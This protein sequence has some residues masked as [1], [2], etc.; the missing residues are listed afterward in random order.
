[1]VAESEAHRLSR[2]PAEPF[3]PAKNAAWASWRWRCGAVVAVTLLAAC[4]GGGSSSGGGG[5]AGGTAPTPGIVD[6]LQA[7][8]AS[9]ALPTLDVTTSVTGTDA[10]SNGVRDDID[11][12]I[13]AQTDTSSQK[14]AL[15]Q[16]AQSV[17]ATLTLDTTNAGATAA[18]A[19]GMR[20]AIACL[21]T[22][23]EPELA[24]GRFH[25]LQEISINTMP[26]LKAYDR[27]NVAMN[28]TVA[29]AET[30]GVCNA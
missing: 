29:H 22:R 12:L 8:V 26:R 3:S 16:V 6:A 2:T 5:G 4:G 14:A 7:M 24:A 27:F 21:F 10:D 19:T 11:A 30:A 20:K 9:G 23:Y 1:M 25:W 13:A 15:T 28:N 17:Q 18:A